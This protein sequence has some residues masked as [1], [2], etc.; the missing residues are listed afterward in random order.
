MPSATTMQAAFSLVSLG[1]ERKA[2]P[3]EKPLRLVKVFNRQI[4]IDL[5][6][7]ALPL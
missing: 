1:V 6:G 5:S 3:F 7:H 4:D 2:Q